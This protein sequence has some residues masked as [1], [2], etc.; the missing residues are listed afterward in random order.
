MKRREAKQGPQKICSGLRGFI[1]K[2]EEV[3]S[4]YE[5]K[6]GIRVSFD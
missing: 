5:D 6:R 2:V 3:A 4:P 1:K